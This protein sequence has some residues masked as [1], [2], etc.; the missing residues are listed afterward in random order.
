MT[1]K[2][3]LEHQDDLALIE[4]IRGLPEE[5]PSPGFARRVLDRLPERKPTLWTRL[6]LWATTPRVLVLTPARLAPLA[7]GLL[8]ALAGVAMML[9]SQQ[10]DPG[11]TI[12]RFVLN[13]PGARAQSVAVVGT[14]NQWQP[15]QA[16]MAYDDQAEAWVLETRVPPG[17]HEYG[18]LIDGR[19]VVPDPSADLTRDD[20]FGNRNSVLLVNGHAI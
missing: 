2:T 6:R 11:T 13:D 10:A 15:E 4:A 18:F 20:G 1:A 14:F 16:E 9:Q 8:L 19:Q 17:S 3:S 5:A 7:A 12:V